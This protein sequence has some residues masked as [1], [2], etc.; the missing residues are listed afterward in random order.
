V[1]DPS[2]ARTEAA[3]RARRLDALDRAGEQ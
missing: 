2:V 3:R 1:V